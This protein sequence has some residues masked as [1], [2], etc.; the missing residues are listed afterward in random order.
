MKTNQ[1][2]CNVSNCVYNHN[3]ECDAQVIE[4]GC[5]CSGMPDCD[6]ETLCCTF[7]KR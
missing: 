2:R 3:H 4:V 1:I 5:C 6:R 7:K